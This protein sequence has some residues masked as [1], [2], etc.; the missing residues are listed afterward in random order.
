MLH[1]TEKIGKKYIYTLLS[2]FPPVAMTGSSLIL[3]S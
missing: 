2:F 3:L 1:S